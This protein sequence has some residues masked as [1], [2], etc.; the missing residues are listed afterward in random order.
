MVSVRKKKKKKGEKKRKGEGNWAFKKI[1]FGPSLLSF[2][3]SFP[4]ILSLYISKEM[5]WFFLV[6]YYCGFSLNMIF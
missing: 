6:E 1:V 2:K 5:I 3:I 4:F